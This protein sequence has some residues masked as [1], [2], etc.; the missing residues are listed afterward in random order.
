MNRSVR[1]LGFGLIAL[2]A[3]SAASAE[4]RP[5]SDG[6]PNPVLVTYEAALATSIDAFRAG[7][8]A[9]VVAEVTQCYGRIPKGG[10]LGPAA[11]PRV[12]RLRFCY[13]LGDAAAETLRQAGI[14]EALPPL[15]H[16]PSRRQTTLT[17][18]ADGEID[19]SAGEVI[20]S[21]WSALGRQALALHGADLATLKPTASTPKDSR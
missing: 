17:L 9:A 18:M 19:R 21:T 16:E 5:V 1:R 2:T 4:D 12:E 14:T 6:P 13:L 3:A 15:L 8:K 20:L 11:R 7:G 10:K